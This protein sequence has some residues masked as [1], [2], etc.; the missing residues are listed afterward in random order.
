MKCIFRRDPD[1]AHVEMVLKLR[2]K[3]LLIFGVTLAA[4]LAFVLFFSRM[5]ILRSF[6]LLEEEE[7]RQQVERAMSAY[8]ED[9]SS[10][11]RTAKDWASWDN[12]YQYMAERDAMDAPS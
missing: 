10:L 5:V 9:L 2:G 6:S 11:D 3:T 8:S 1:R 4:L 7:T 12:L